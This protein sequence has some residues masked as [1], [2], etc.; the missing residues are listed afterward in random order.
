MKHLAPRFGSSIPFLCLAAAVITASCG[1]TVPTTADITER[2][3]TILTYPFGDP[4]PLPIF[5]RASM[6][7]QGERL[8]PYFSFDGYSGKG[9]DR[10]WTVVRLRN[11]FVEVAVLPEVGGKVWGAVDR[12]TGRE[13]LYWNHVLKFRQIALR[14]PWTSGG[15]EFNFGVMG[16]A[17]STASPVDYATRR[18]ADGSVSVTV[19]NLD[20][21]SRT[22]WSVTMTLHPESAALET[23]AVWR[24]ATPYNQSY[25]YWSCAA[26]KA[27]D[28]LKYI[29]PGRWQIG[30]DYSVPLRPWPIDETGRD[31]S[32]YADNDSPD[33]KSYFTVGEAAE[34]YGAWYKGPDSGFGHWS[35]YEDMPGKKV[36]IWDLSRSGGIWVDLLT[37]S[38]GQY[39]EPQA[40]RLLNQSDHGDFPAGL[41]DEWRELWFPYGG[42][43]PLVGA[44]PR[45]VLGLRRNDGRVE[46]G[47]YAIEALR[48]ELTVTASGKVVFREILE[49]GPSA[50]WKKALA[51]KM[52]GPDFEVRIGREL[53]YTTDVKA[54]ALDRPFNFHN[55]TGPSAEETYLQ[56]RRFERE[57]DLSRALDLYSACVEKE[58]SHVRALARLAEHRLR[59]GEVEEGRELS[60]RALAIS[61]YDP[62]ANYLYGLAS[63]LAGRRHDAEEA[64][65]WA[66]RSPLF[67]TA[68]LCRTAESA[69]ADKDFA[70]A[71]EFAGRAFAADG[72]N[73]QAADTLAAAL[74]LAG[75]GREAG[76]VLD[77]ILEADPLD[78]LA[79]FERYLLSRRAADLDDFRSFI[80][81]ELP[82]ETCLE[83]A[84]FYVRTGLADDAVLLLRNAP[85]QA[86]ISF[87]LAWILRDSDPAE[88]RSR[89]GKAAA[90]SPE[91]VFPYR[92]EAIPV[93][94]WAAERLPEDW[95]PKYYLALI[96]WGKGRLPE[97]LD[98]LRRCDGSDYWP[99]YASRAVLLENS[100]LIEK[101]AADYGKAADL[102]R[103]SWRPLHVLAGFFLRTGRDNEALAAARSAADSFP[104]N[105]P[106]QIDLVKA[107]LACDRYQEAAS[108]LD[109][110]TVLPSEGATEVHG[111]FVRAEL[112]LA[113]AGLEAGNWAGAAA[114]LEKSR[115]FPERLGT[116]Q[117]FDPDFRLQ[118]YFAAACLERMGDKAGA[119][120]MKKDILSY[121][122]KHADK[123]GPNSW[124]AGL[125]L[126][127][128]GRKAEARRLLDG[129]RPESRVVG[130]ALELK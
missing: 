108:V 44:T 5:A 90:A 91:L 1:K 36:W 96:Y 49:L 121:T 69:M 125:V 55:P 46:L 3:E 65:G 12:S 86:E 54:A 107:L 63:L 48:G 42:I 33:S 62:E 11:R 126:E 6:G 95:K 102:A 13:F 45:A 7:G 10:D 68:A 27:A 110:L 74:R 31:L 24:N 127:R 8:Y 89:L 67:R 53:Y 85:E 59:R 50:S 32:L 122:E 40:G 58:P 20:L 60:R 4:D 113:M 114:H 106:I 119:D 41:T 17:P 52:T 37:D 21:P 103:G 34:F 38:D 124:F 81:N 84:M 19:G 92:E 64:L 115:R 25:Y 35:R 2:R 51:E 105:G 111:L 61:M 66:A 77:R 26:I 112:A 129:P 104:S 43:G 116:G 109:T 100:G 79:R 76:L 128:S 123:P 14:G 98:E 15:I 94:K 130:L 72:R 9:L 18:N 70:R 120:K 93:F 75:K 82:H 87:W 80:R 99:M 39:T 118:D 97:A 117:P 83:L 88:S 22:R 57:R 73:T 29:F 28:D 23:S 101:A 47:V 56:A 71:V 78:H 30:H 16:H